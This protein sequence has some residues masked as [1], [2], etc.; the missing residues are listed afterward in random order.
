MRGPAYT[1]NTSPVIVESSYWGTWYSYIKDDYLQKVREVT[2]M[3]YRNMYSESAT[4]TFYTV[5]NY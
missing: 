2:A 1:I 4:N 3:L 5:G